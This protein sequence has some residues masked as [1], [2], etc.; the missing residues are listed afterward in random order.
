[1]SNVLTIVFDKAE[2]K[3]DSVIAAAVNELHNLG[4]TVKEVRVAGD[5]GEAKIAL[6]QVEGIVDTAGETL[7]ADGKADLAALTTSGAT[8]TVENKNPDGSS[9][10][11]HVSVPDAALPEDVPPGQTPPQTVDERRLALLDELEA[12]DKEEEASSTTTTSTTEATTT[13]DPTNSGGSLLTNPDATPG[14]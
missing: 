10:V 2:Q 7:V 6:N 1:M 13:V 11:A 3:V 14:S 4:H 12:L 9:P 8:D 5:A